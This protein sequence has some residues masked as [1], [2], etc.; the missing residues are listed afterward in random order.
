MENELLE[1]VM[2]YNLNLQ[3]NRFLKNNKRKN[4][5]F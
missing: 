2:Q 3:G 4:K 1:P 5:R